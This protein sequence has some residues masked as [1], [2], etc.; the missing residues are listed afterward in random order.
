VRLNPI[1]DAPL[2]LTMDGDPADQ[3]QPVA[4]QRRRF[5]ALLRS[6]DDDSWRAPTRCAGWTVQDVVAHLVT[7][8]AFW[9][10]SVRA[11]LDGEPTRVLEHFDPVAH[12]AL[13][14]EPMRAL[15]PAEVFEQ[16]SAS[17]TGFLDALASIHDEQWCA[18]GESPAGHVTMR[19]LAHHALWDCWIHERDVAL[20]LG[21]DAA[22]EADEVRSCLR[23]A[24]AIGPF[25]AR[26]WPERVEGSFAVEATSPE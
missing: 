24:A 5:E 10:A 6:L 7:V 26:S 13:L 15:A 18:I 19:L 14:V 2:A 12:P 17:N 21:L 25:L 4:R 22:V 11:G 20:P 8:N 1:Y 9:E 3:A 23:Y 16:F